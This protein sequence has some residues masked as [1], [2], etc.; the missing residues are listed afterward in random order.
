MS[1]LADVPDGV[2]L[3]YALWKA[4]RG[5][6]RGTVILLHGRT[7]CIEKY[8]ETVTD[9]RG[10]G[11]DV[12]TFDWRGQGASTRLL[13]DS[14]KGHVDHFNQYLDDLETILTQVALPDCRPPLN[15]LGH[16]TGGLVA[17]LAA[18]A[19]AN[20][21]DRMML[22]SPLLAL[23]N[24]PVKQ[25]HLQRVLAV[26]SYIG[27]GRSLAPGTH[28]F[29]E[30]RPFEKNF[31]TTDAARYRRNGEIFSHH[32]E[33]GIGGPTTAWLFAACWAMR[34]VGTA[35]H[36]QSINIPTI[37][38]AAGADPVVDSAAVE[39]Y[40]QRMRSGSFL[41]IP[42]ALHELLQERDAYRE[43]VLAAFDAFIESGEDALAE[44]L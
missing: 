21:I 25:I 6:T 40:G 2:K 19:L 42:R 39:R 31:L 12:L 38:V 37:L 43:Q 35:H 11:F 23:N 17:L 36:A 28:R 32:P 1:G 18:P 44:R 29:P 20:R 14:R 13:N 16:S 34:Q 15:I 41:T 22:L 5:E 4:G 3:R 9:L 10:R 24:L 30:R 27:F 7:E 8:F 33:L 26:L